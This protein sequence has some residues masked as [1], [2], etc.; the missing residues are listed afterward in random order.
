MQ[1]T[2]GHVFVIPYFFDLL[3]DFFAVTDPDLSFNEKCQ[4][5]FRVFKAINN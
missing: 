3:P 2:M 5:T 1:R 4:I